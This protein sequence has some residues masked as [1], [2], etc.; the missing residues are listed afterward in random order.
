M[1]CI[2]GRKLFL[3]I[4]DIGLLT[5]FQIQFYEASLIIAI[6]YLHERQLYFLLSPTPYILKINNFLLFINIIYAFN[7]K[8]F[9]F[10]ITFL[11]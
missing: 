4:R 5:K 11:F 6:D 10:N 1:E 3:V 2:K 7:F 8:I 9:F